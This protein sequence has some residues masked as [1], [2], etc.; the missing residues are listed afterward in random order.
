MPLRDD[1]ASAAELLRRLDRTLTAFPCHLHV[2]LVDD[3]SNQP[4]DPA[5]FQSHFA[6]VR[7]IDVVRLR[8][9][10]G[11]QRAI[12]VGIVHIATGDPY[13]AVVIMDADGE[14][15]P[16]GVLEL[17]RAFTSDQRGAKAIFAER[18]RRTESL[19]FQASY[20]LYKGAHRILTGVRVRVGN[21]SILPWSYLNTLV[22][23][24]E[25]WNHYAAA[26]FRSGLPFTM[27]PIA[28]GHRIAGKSKMNF[29]SLVV[30][31][32]S[33]IS[34]FG[35]V[36]GVRILIMSLGGSLLAVLGILTVII[37]RFFTDK[38]V[39]GWA[40]YSV[41]V[42]TIIFMQLVTIA[43]GFT[44]TMLSNRATFSFVPLRDCEPFILK[45]QE[46]Y[47]VD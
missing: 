10:L 26:L 22:V 39:P 4:P 11:H 44:F 45:E 19:V 38:A 23:M 33:A 34:V 27:T 29:V 13:D 37:I 20:K 40:T 15:T 41:G 35:I 28:R 8:R 47:R 32:M 24:S 30:H 18:T 7:S 17:L 21:F 9:N 25:L 12:A 31:G 1:W 36:I 2:V 6:V 3:G 46:V 42:L 14:D 16:E 43:A 5:D